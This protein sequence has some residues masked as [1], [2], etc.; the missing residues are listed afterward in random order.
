MHSQ[1]LMNVLTILGLNGKNLS[2]SYYFIQFNNF[3]FKLFFLKKQNKSNTKKINKKIKIIILLV[4][5]RPLIDYLISGPIEDSP[6]S[7]L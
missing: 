5:K 1:V 7:G 2:Y 6:I 4:I 3:Y